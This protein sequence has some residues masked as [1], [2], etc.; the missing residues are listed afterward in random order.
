MKTIHFLLLPV[1]ALAA[2]FS[3][4]C[5]TTKGFGQDL[6]KVGNRLETRADETGGAEPVRP[7]TGITAPAPTVATPPAY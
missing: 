1:A 7:S 4:S 2:V 6:Q 3:S 5:A